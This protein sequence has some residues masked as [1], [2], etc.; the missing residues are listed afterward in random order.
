M[1]KCDIHLPLN[2]SDGE[3]IEQEKIMRVREE[4]VAAFG[5]FAAADR[6]AWRYDGVRYVEIM[7]FEV[8][9]TDD[10]LTRERLKEFKR[11]LLGFLQ[12]VDILITT[13]RIQTV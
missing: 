2:R 1:K 13:S 10:K 11:R 3:P 7:R 12:Q 9:T 8:V 6:R 4:L 5:S